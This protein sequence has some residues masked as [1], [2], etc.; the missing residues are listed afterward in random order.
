MPNRKKKSEPV[1]I[2]EIKEP[3]PE[4]PKAVEEVDVVETFYEAA[5]VLCGHINRQFRNSDG[6][7]EDLTCKLPK[8]H[9]GDHWSKFTSAVAEY[10]LDENKRTVVTGTH[11][12]EKDGYWSDGAGIPV[13]P[14]LIT[15][16]EDFKR[17][18]DTRARERGTDEGL[19]Q[20]L[21][22]EVRKSFGG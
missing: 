10:G 7:L 19:S 6:E 12:K 17:L 14:H 22:G 8:G 11:K 21:D 5:Q 9:D 1:V 13:A 2:P 15:R 18:Q 3:A 16:E 20:K 4:A